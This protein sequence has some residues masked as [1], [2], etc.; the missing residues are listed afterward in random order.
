MNFTF[1]LIIFVTALV[2]CSMGFKR[3]VWFMSVGYGFA[4]SGVGV[5]SIVYGILNKIITPVQLIGFIIMTIYGFRLGYFLYRRETKNATYKKILDAK[6]GKEPP[7]FVKVFMWLFM[8][9][10]YVAQT[11]GLHFRMLNQTNDN[12]ALYIG[13]IVM[14][15][16][17]FIEALADKQK[18]AQKKE[19]PDF[20]ACKGLFKYSRCASYF[21]EITFWTGVFITGFTSNNGIAQWV[22][23]TLGYILIVYIMVDGAKRTEKGHIAR[24]GNNPEYI[25]YSNST[26]V[27]IPF[28]PVYHIYNP[29][30]ERKVH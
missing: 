24:Y 16:G 27:L 15:L 4:V 11:S 18:S 6:V 7:V 10:L 9:V 1:L 29:N 2:C 20:V 14:A 26:P 25:Q 21:G 13:V 22:V 12:I 3:F 5:A 17:A 19:R 8:G 23:A 30:K 28:I